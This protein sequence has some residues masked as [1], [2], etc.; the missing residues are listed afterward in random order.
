MAKTTAQK[1]EL[2]LKLNLLHPN[3]IPPSLPTR[4]LRWIVSYGRYIVI[5]TEVI[6]VS[7]FVFRFKLDADLDQLKT[8]LNK[9]VPYIEGLISSEALIRQT[10][11]KLQT[12]GGNY[13]NSPDWEKI[14]NN[15]SDEMPLSATLQTLNIDNSDEKTP[16][17][18]FKIIGSA[19]SSNDLGVFI[20]KLREKKDQANTKVFKDISLD[21]LSLD[22]NKLEF[23]ISGGV[24]RN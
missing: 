9:D 12:I 3:E 18:A 6:V 23:S 8:D 5:F 22:K 20:K 15:I 1:K 21:S 2:R 14:F 10:Q 17:L 4:F 16:F 19:S 11:L 13:D 7:A 24:K